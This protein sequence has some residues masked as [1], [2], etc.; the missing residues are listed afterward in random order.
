M[1]ILDEL[2]DKYSVEFDSELCS[3]NDY[4]KAISELHEFSEGLTEGSADKVEIITESLA[5]AA[6]HAGIKAGMWLGARIAV[7]LIVEDK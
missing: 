5:T 6:F 2:T 7:G 4:Q 3:N 1:D